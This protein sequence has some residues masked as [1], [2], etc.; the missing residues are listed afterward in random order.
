MI[1][2]QESES[3]MLKAVLS[4]LTIL[5]NKKNKKPESESM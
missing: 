1:N 2:F 5:L 3:Q 4:I